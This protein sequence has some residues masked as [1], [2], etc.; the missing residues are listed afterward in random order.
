M[1]MRG[2][3]HQAATVTL[4][5]VPSGLER[6]VPTPERELDPGRDPVGRG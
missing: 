6:K 4:W 1:A 5:S 2:P 3:E